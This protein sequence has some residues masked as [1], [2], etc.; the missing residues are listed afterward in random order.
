MV[1]CSVNGGVQCVNAHCILVC[2]VNNCWVV[3]SVHGG[4]GGHC[5][6]RVVCSVRIDHLYELFVFVGARASGVRW[7]SRSST[8]QAAGYIIGPYGHATLVHTLVCSVIYTAQ[9]YTAY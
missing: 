1:V 8:L 4:G 9:L 6:H 3:C 2:S 5:A 7:M